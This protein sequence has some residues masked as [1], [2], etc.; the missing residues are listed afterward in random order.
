MF[1]LS[2][3]NVENREHFEHYMCSILL[4]LVNLPKINSKFKT[5]NHK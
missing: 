5:E 1:V 3:K 2:Y 4:L